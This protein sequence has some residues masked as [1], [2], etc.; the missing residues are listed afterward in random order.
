MYNAGADK[1]ADLLDPM[2]TY[3]KETK[4]ALI[5][6]IEN[7]KGYKTLICSTFAK[8]LLLDY[9]RG[10]DRENIKA[11][12]AA[13]YD[14]SDLNV[15][16]LYENL[17]H[18]SLTNEHYKRYKFRL[19]TEI[20]KQGKVP[21]IGDISDVYFPQLKR[22]TF[23]KDNMEGIITN[24]Q[25]V[26]LNHDSNTLFGEY[27]KPMKRTQGCYDAVIIF[28]QDAFSHFFG[29]KE[30]KATHIVV[31]LQDTTSK[32]HSI[33]ELYMK[34]T[35]ENIS[36]QV[37]QEITETTTKQTTTTLKQLQAM[38]GLKGSSLTHYLVFVVPE[39]RFEKNYLAKPSEHKNLKVGVLCVPMNFNEEERNYINTDH[40]YKQIQFLQGQ[41]KRKFDQTQ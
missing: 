18:L 31:F 24:V 10:R 30:D 32:N 37:D 20:A 14:L 6:P 23:S 34:Q 8:L 38:P 4:L 22:V 9:V 15:G 7:F 5:Y 36:T 17:C 11:F 33:K 29:I 41:K 26:S 2:T 39:G 28:E 40:I 27:Y 12:V 35:V 3:S 25:P 21:N 16:D 19:V 1:F 13:S